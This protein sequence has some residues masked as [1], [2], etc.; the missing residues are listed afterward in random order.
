MKK[1]EYH[2]DR[3]LQE[4][5]MN[6]EGLCRGFMINKT[7]CIVGLFSSSPTL[8]TTHAIGTHHKQAVLCHVCTNACCTADSH[9]FVQVRTVLR[10]PVSLCG[11]CKTSRR[12]FSDEACAQRQLQC[13]AVVE[14]CK[15]F[16]GSRSSTENLARPGHSCH[17]VNPDTLCKVDQMV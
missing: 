5:K 16:K 10:H 14:W 7:I 2:S 11:R 17:V 8:F 6:K 13:T 12:R 1:S 3:W 15:R 4:S 9:G